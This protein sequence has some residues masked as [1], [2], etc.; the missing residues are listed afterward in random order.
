MSMFGC[1]QNCLSSTKIFTIYSNKWKHAYNWPEGSLTARYLLQN[2]K[3]D[4]SN[5]KTPLIRTSAAQE[6]KEWLPRLWT[7]KWVLVHV[8]PD[9][10]LFQTA[11]FCVWNFVP[12]TWN[13]LPTDPTKPYELYIR[14]RVKRKQKV[15]L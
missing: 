3:C 9:F 2:D 14:Y 5:M 15:S 8:Q 7:L 6:I 13:N 11:T 4:L 1:F 12:F 10:V